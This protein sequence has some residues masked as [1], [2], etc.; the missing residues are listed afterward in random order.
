MFFKHKSLPNH[1]FHYPVPIPNHPLAESP[2]ARSRYLHCK[3]RQ[4]CQLRIRP[5][6]FRSAFTP[7]AV[8]PLEDAQGVF[9]GCLR[10]N[11]THQHRR[12]AEAET[13]CRLI[14]LSAGNVTID[15]DRALADQPDAEVFDEW[16]LPGCWSQ[17]Q[18]LYEFYNVMWVEYDDNTVAYRKAVGRVEAEAWDRVA[19]ELGD[20]TLG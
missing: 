18:G 6:D 5:G 15:P 2:V 13:T 16:H 11:D 10:L 1:E 4:T 8:A 17:R 9:V 3:T 20:I 19:T 7:C 12:D 14:E